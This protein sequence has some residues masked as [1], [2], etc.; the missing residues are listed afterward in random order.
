MYVAHCN[1][2]EERLKEIIWHWSDPAAFQQYLVF[3]YFLPYLQAND[4]RLA[5]DIHSKHFSKVPVYGT[6]K[7]L[8]PI[9][10]HKRC[11]K[12]IFS[13][14]FIFWYLST[15]FM[16]KVISQRATDPW[17]LTLPCGSNLNTRKLINITQARYKAYKNTD[18]SIA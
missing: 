15:I 4:A 16:Y 2:L 12:F 13:Y 14:P 18:I 10:T 5:L 17:Y 7:K 3:P 8:T 1:V 6:H 9:V 11:L